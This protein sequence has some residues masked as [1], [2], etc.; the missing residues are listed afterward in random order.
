MEK[1][2][3]KTAAV[4]LLAG[5]S[6][7]MGSP[8][9]HVKLGKLTFLERIVQTLKDN[10]DSIHNITLVGQKTDLK[11]KSLAQENGGIWLE[12]P[13]PELGPLS[14][15]RLA[16]KTLS[17]FSAFLLWPVDHPMV[18]SDTVSKLLELHKLYPESIIIPSTGERRGHPSLFP[19]WCFGLFDEIPLDVGARGILEKYPDRIKHLVVNDAWIRKNLNNLDALKEA[20]NAIEI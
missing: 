3:N 15:I 5:F 17:G 4:I 20:Q 19:S 14:S 1:T 11:S 6:T 16:V 13:Q 8:K 18:T 2:N 12:N 9:Q 10:N 7:R